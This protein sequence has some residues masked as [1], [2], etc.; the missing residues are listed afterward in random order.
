[1][2]LGIAKRF[3]LSRRML[4]E[5][6]DS[7]LS[8][9]KG[10]FIMTEEYSFTEEDGRVLRQ[11]DENPLKPVHS[12]MVENVKEEIIQAYEAALEANDKDVIKRM[13]WEFSTI[14]VY[15]KELKEYIAKRKGEREIIPDAPI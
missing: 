3:L 4:Y 9:R 10:F 14:G 5:R 7:V 12:N 8:S 15:K 1:M 13:E 11:K 6:S 2:R